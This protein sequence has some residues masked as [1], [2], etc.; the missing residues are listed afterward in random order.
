MEVH[1]ITKK[2]ANFGRD[3]K[4]SV[5]TPGQYRQRDSL[6][7][8]VKGMAIILMVAGHAE[9][10]DMLVRFI[11]LFHMPV[12]F[13]AAGYFFSRTS[14]DAPWRFCMKRVR[15]LYFPFVK[16]ALLFLV[17]H[18]VLFYFGILNETYGNW[19]GGVTHPY[20]L[21]SFFQRL[22]HIIFSMAGY[23]EFM[24]GAFWFF[25]ALLVTSVGYVLL[26]L[27]L[28][29]LF[30]QL[31]AVRASLIICVAALAFALFKIGCDMRIVTIVQ[32]GIRETWGIFFFSFGVIFRALESRL[33]RMRWWNALAIFA[34]LVAGSWLEWTGM[35]LTPTL[36]TVATLPVTGILGFMML[37]W[38]ARHID[39]HDNVLRRLFVTVGE[40]TMCV[41]VFHISAFKLVSLVKIWWYGLDFAQI[42]CHMVIHE[43]A[44]DDLFWIA[45]TAVGV[46]VPIIWKLVYDRV[47]ARIRHV[48]AA[49]VSVHSV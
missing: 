42:G 7:S 34:F 36:L 15:G 20:T 23:D 17:L 21:H 43:H 27:L 28:R 5:V 48:G 39:S 49:A 10:G 44:A 25:R 2:I 35:T 16:W 19:T 22:V 33:P 41:F 1:K 8:I 13:I 3:M 26:R 24:A 11:Y 9:G 31:D 40:M 18:N 37:R 47:T 4:N 12:F 46:A 32:G 14:L 29:H 38:L 6:M 30:P 45:Y